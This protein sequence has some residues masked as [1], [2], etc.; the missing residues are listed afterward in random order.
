VSLA[1]SV[2]DPVDASA[3][4]FP[5]LAPPEPVE[6]P[7]LREDEAPP[8]PVDVAPLEADAFDIAPPGACDSEVGAPRPVPSLLFDVPHA[9]RTIDA[10]AMANRGHRSMA[11]K[12]LIPAGYLDER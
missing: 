2:G 12:S 8:G 10:A 4:W 1:A 5:E 11:E 7:T 3:G 9:A 6:V